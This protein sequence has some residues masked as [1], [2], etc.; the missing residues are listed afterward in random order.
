MSHYVTFV[1]ISYQLVKDC[2]AAAGVGVGDD[3]VFNP[4]TKVCDSLIN[5]PSC[6][7]D[8]KCTSAYGNFAKFPASCTNYWLC[9]DS[10]PYD[11]V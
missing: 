3:L 8:F 6:I 9:A 5:V 10:V 11:Q 7:A 4:T 2:T 1:L